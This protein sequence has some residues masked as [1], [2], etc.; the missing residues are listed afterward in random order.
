M[1]PWNEVTTMCPERLE[2]KNTGILD[3]QIAG[4]VPDFFLLPGNKKV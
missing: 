2:E 4:Q 1:F 3:R